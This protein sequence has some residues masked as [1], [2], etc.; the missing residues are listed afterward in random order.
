MIG[1]LFK[2][3]V[4]SRND[5][6]LRRYGAKVKRINA[7]EEGVRRL[8]DKELAGK[9]PE[10]RKRL[11]EGAALADLLEEAF[12]Y[13]RESARR[14]LEMRHF[15]VQ[16]M[17]GMALFD[18]KVTEMRTGE[19]KTLVATLP[20]YLSALEGKGVHIVTVN[21]YLAMRDARWMSKVYLGLGMSVGVN[22]PGLSFEQKKQSYGADITY[23]TNNEFGFDYL[24]DNMR[25][26]YDQKVQRELNYAIVDEVDS[27]LIDEARTPLII[28]GESDEHIHLYKVANEVAP[29]FVCQQGEIR[30][31]GPTEDYSPGD[32]TLELKT[33]HVHLTESGYEKAEAL[34]AERSLLKEGGLYDTNNLALLHHL[35]SALR[36]HH[37][38]ERD[39]EYVVQNGQVVIVDEFTGRLM[40]GRRWGEGLHQAVEAKEGVTVEKE[41]LTLASI[42]FQNYF[43]LY[44]KLAGMTGTA[45][46]E[47]SEFHQIYGLETVIV[48]THQKMVRKDAL[49]KIYQ[50]RAAKFRAVIADIRESHEKGQ[51]LLVGTASIESSEELSKWLAQENLQH[52][53]LN[54][55]EH[56]REAQ[57]IAQAGMPGAVTI[58]TN[59][60][61]RGTDIVLGGNLDVERGVLQEQMKDG[62]E[63]ERTAALAQL[64]EDWKTRH[65]RVVAAGGLRIIGTERHESRRIDNQL[66]GRS[67]RQGDPGSSIFYLSFEDPLLRI[68]ASD[69]VARIMDRLKIDE[70]EAI[71][72]RMVTR[73][74]ENAQRKVEAQNF[75]A[76]KQLLEYDDIANDQRRI[77]YEQREQIMGAAD[78]DG[79][80]HEFCNETLAG[81]AGNYIPPGSPEEEWRL[82]ELEQA[83]LGDLK[84]SLPVRKWISEDQEMDSTHIVARMKTETR[85]LMEE[86]LGD[87]DRGQF[88]DFQRSLVLNIVDVHWRQ[89]L[90]SLDHLRQSIGLRGY[91]HKNPKQEYKRESLAM[92][93]QMIDTIRFETARILFSLRVQRN[94]MSHVEPSR[95]KNIRHEHPDAEDVGSAG[96]QPAEPGTDRKLAQ[97]RSQVAPKVGRNDPCPC[98]SGKKF[99]HCHGTNG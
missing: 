88:G 91:A 56:A 38:Y 55:K 33:R 4:G 73:V 6:L 74:I 94:E 57:I 99:K 85:R 68:F 46:T 63:E 47:A 70:D 52:S 35:T 45:D 64:Q 20:V 78:I 96:K 44:G 76:R 98:G 18:G 19:G 60:A 48:P 2:A 87:A 71:E 65:E 67:G 25:L 69:R 29:Q 9:T 15:D 3:V 11:A 22:V 62:S 40:P 75:D 50:T 13:V 95:P 61:G 72:A 41:T 12:S 34:F 36:A 7:M 27:I 5:R 26:R 58:A 89:H 66:R 97:S 53:V 16:L 24:R 83:L 30:Q 1:G 32:F 17:G 14:H 82:E 8:S 81:L 49:D 84:L 28:S 39:R 54:A 93:N 90:S 31:D 79:I 10:L 86:K 21:D 92:F 43:R 23:G 77:I 59:M 51:P 37:I 80:T 42:T